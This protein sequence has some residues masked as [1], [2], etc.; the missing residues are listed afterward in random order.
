MADGLRHVLLKNAD[1]E[2]RF[3]S[4][5]TFVN[6]TQYKKY[7]KEE[8]DY[9]KGLLKD[10]LGPV[11][12]SDNGTMFKESYIS[13][14][15][16]EDKG[17]YWTVSPSKKRVLSSLEKV[18]Q[19]GNR[20]HQ[21]IGANSYTMKVKCR[22]EDHIFSLKNI[23]IDMDC[24]DKKEED[25]ESFSYLNICKANEF[26][27][28]IKKQDAIPTPNL[29][30]FTGRGIQIWYFLKPCS[31]KLDFIYKAVAERLCGQMQVFAN[32]QGMT[33]DKTASIG[34]N[35]IFRIP[36]TYNPKAHVFS[37]CV[38]LSEHRYPLQE[39][40]NFLSIDLKK[41]GSCSPNRKSVVS[42]HHKNEHSSTLQTK[43]F[44]SAEEYNSSSV[45]R[46]RCKVI[47]SIIKS[48]RE[49]ESRENLL[50]LYHNFALSL[51]EVDAVSA[52]HQLN[53]LFPVPLKD[54]EIKALV[55]CN[56]KKEGYLYT[57]ASFFE[58]AAMTNDEIDSYYS[59]KGS[60]SRSKNRVRDIRR[61]EKKQQRIQLVQRL[62]R[63]G[64][65]KKYKDMDVIPIKEIAENAQCS[66]NTVYKYTASIR[67]GIEREAKYQE[68]CAYLKKIRKAKREEK[69]KMLKAGVL[70]D[71]SAL[72]LYLLVRLQYEVACY[73]C[74]VLEGIY[75]SSRPAIRKIQDFLEAALSIVSGEKIDIIAVIRAG[76]CLDKYKKVLFITRDHRIYRLLIDVFPEELNRYFILEEGYKKKQE[77]QEN[78]QIQLMQ[79]Q[80]KMVKEFDKK[81]E[82]LRKNRRKTAI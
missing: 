82:V 40:Q 60:D 43:R 50:F 51:P 18:L 11:P 53:R 6:G 39:L 75:N 5:I 56:T 35:R 74:K 72:Q 46:R 13:C 16:T 52:V 19:S 44:F 26:L 42:S 61:R 22:D 8:I 31:K 3:H 49:V 2:K 9:Y 70:N 55:K 77:R 54:R 30:N 36:G 69:E 14:Q 21:Y 79:R 15:M 25:A 73:G 57:D 66:I 34:I 76:L 33:I 47:E 63:Y 38:R 17:F 10:I 45:C 64:R 12:E 68:A 71:S 29:V 41:K 32:E 4:G 20:D 62:Y 67:K 1:V 78:V 24:H 48:G 37:Q 23:V 81:L 59:F 58:K 27:S 65:T 7:T 80:E 28:W